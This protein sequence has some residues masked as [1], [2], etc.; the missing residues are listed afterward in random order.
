MYMGPYGTKVVP[1][2]FEYARDLQIYVI[3]ATCKVH[4]VEQIKDTGHELGYNDHRESTV[5]FLYA[6][7]QFNWFNPCST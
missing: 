1:K 3:R 6:M 7:I 4:L 2:M 5:S